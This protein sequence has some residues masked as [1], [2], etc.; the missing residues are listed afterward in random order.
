MVTFCKEPELPLI[1][2]YAAIRV[3]FP[4]DFINNQSH[5]D[6]NISQALNDFLTEAT[7]F[8]SSLYKWEAFAF[9]FVK[10]VASR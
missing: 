10:T 8:P 5:T 6:I 9:Q 2:K 3:F 7:S 4:L 1:N